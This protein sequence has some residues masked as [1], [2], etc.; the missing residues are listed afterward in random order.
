MPPDGQ[1]LP[2]RSAVPVSSVK[3]GDR[4]RKDLGD[5]EALAASI[6]DLGL[7]H[8]IVIAADGLLLAGERRLAAC[9]LL[10]WATIP[11]TVIEGTE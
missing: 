1:R 9:K 11:A 5:I 10:G 4:H 2:D 3:I 6:R 8:P 7:L